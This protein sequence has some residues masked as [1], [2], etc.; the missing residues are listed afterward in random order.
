MSKDHR[1][2]TPGPDRM[3][4]T[5]QM[6]TMIRTEDPPEPPEVSS[7]PGLSSFSSTLTPLPDTSSVLVPDLQQAVSA[8]PS[9]PIDLSSQRD[10]DDDDADIEYDDPEPLEPVGPSTIVRGYAHDRG[11]ALLTDGSQRDPY[12]EHHVRDLYAATA[13]MEK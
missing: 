6:N 12:T 4:G 8:D 10:N 3:Q 1:T 9:E 7:A 2:I 11:V 13:M 5:Y